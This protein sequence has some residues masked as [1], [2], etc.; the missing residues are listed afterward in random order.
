M[1]TLFS[2]YPIFTVTVI[3]V[4]CIVVLFLGRLDP[5]LEEILSTGIGFIFVELSVIAILL[6]VRFIGKKLLFES[7]KN[8]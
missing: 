1:L 5:R 4:S 2:K 8:G 3:I 7:E 6:I